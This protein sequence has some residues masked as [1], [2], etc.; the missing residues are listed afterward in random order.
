MMLK[1][2]KWRRSGYKDDEDENDRGDEDNEESFEEY[3]GDIWLLVLK[4]IPKQT[5]FLQ[6]VLYLITF[7]FNNSSVSSWRWL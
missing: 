1:W 3:S 2:G 5:G 4:Y 6:L 7:G